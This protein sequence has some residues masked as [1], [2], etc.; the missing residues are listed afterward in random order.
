MMSS[1]QPPSPDDLRQAKWAVAGVIVFVL[2]VFGWWFHDEWWSK[3]GLGEGC[4]G[5]NA[6]CHSELCL[7]LAESRPETGRWVCSEIC[8]DEGDCPDHMICGRAE[9]HVGHGTQ[10]LGLPGSPRMACLP[11]GTTP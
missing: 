1:G 7:E 4:G 10:L 3:A 11:R 5:R 2:V 9:L 6:A 8:V